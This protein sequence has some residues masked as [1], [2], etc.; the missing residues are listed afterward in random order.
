M[1]NVIFTFMFLSSLFCF[2]QKNNCESVRVGVFKIDVGESPVQ[3]ITRN[4][5][6][7]FEEIKEFDYKAR[8]EINWIDD[9][10]YELLNKKVLQG[11]LPMEIPKDLIVRIKI[12][13]VEDDTV[14][15][16]CSSNLTDFVA[17]LKM[18]IISRE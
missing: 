15:V 17:D 11:N 16:R 5:K 9:C 4:D 18:D 13:N 10:T 7:Q 6:Y 2:G 1:K 3:V 8:F 14:T 12:L